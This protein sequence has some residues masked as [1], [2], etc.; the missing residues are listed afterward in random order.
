MMENFT[1]R[2]EP[3]PGTYHEVNASGLPVKEGHTA[4]IA[5]GDLLPPASALGYHWQ[6]DQH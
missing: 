6:I 2:T 4:I 5:K 1:K 3:V